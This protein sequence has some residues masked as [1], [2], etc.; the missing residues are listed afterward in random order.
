MSDEQKNINDYASVSISLASPDEIRQWS[1]GEVKKSETI[2]Y[3]TY[4]PE[5]EGL[6]CERIFGPE[7]DWECSC[8]K[9]K[10]IK[11]K[12]IVCDRCGVKITHSRV[13]RERMGHITLAAP[14]VHIW[15]FKTIPSKL[16]NL[17]GVKTAPL[18]RVIY[19]QDYIVIDPGNTE[20]KKCQVLTEQEYR[21]YLDQYGKAFTAGMGAE[22]IKEIL[23]T[24]NLKELSDKLREEL[25]STRSK[26]KVED[27]VKRLKLV[28]DLRDS[29]NRP[30]WLVLDVL[31]V[32]PPELRPLVFLESG[33]FATSDLNDL[34]RRVINRN[35]RLKKLIALKAPDVIVR[36]EKRML[37]QSVDALFDNSR[38][39][40][41]VMGTN[42]RSLKSLTDLIK[43]KQGRFRENLLGKRVDY[44]ARSVIVVG[45]ELKLHQC[46]L[47][48]KIALELYQPFIIRRLK[49]L[50]FADTIKSAKKFIE[51]KDPEVWDVLDE[52]IHHHP[53]L[54]NRAPTLH[55]MGIQAFEP[56]L[57]EGNA[58]RLHPLV[59]RGFNADFD[60]DT[61]AVHLPLSVEAQIEA[62][63]LM[64]STNNIFSPADGRPIMAPSQD[65]VMG[66]YFFSCIV[67]GCRGE[68]QFFSSPQEV[69]TAF[70]V[71]AL[72]L[73]AKIHVA[74]SPV[75]RAKSDGV[76]KEISGDRI[77]I[78]TDVYD[79]KAING[80]LDSTQYLAGVL[81]AKDLVVGDK[82]KRGQVISISDVI[83][84]DGQHEDCHVDSKG[85]K[86]HGVYSTNV[87]RMIFNDILG[88]RLPYYN[89]LLR[90]KVLAS[91]INDC[92]TRYTRQET[93]MMVDDIKDFG[94]KAST[95][96]GLSFSVADL[97]VTQEKQ[98]LIADADA[99]VERSQSFYEKGAITDQERYKEVIETWIHCREELYKN[100]M[101]TLQREKLN[102]IYIMADSGA[103]GGVAQV[104]QL[105]GMRG[106]MAKPSGEILEIP[107]T[108]NFRD[109]LGV[110]E[111]FSST[112]GSRKGLAD[113]ALKT[114]DS[115]YMTRKLADVVQ[116]ITVTQHDC[117]TLNGVTK[118]ELWKGDHVEIPMWQLLNG[119]VSRHDI[120]DR[121]SGELVVKENEIFDETKARKVEKLGYS[122]I[123]VRSPL[124]CES[125]TGICQMCYGYDLSTSRLV[126]LGTAVGIIAA[127]SIGEPGTQL[128]MQTF[129]IGGVASYQLEQND[130]KTRNGGTV[131][132]E[133]LRIVTNREGK[134][135]VI[136]RNGELIVEPENE[137]LDE[138][139]RF[140]VPPGAILKVKDGDKVKRGTVMAQFEANTAPIIAHASGR[141]RFGDI[142]P[143]K[144]V[145]EDVDGSTG[146]VR[147][148]VMDHRGELHP[149]III[150]DKSGQVL[151]TYPV[152]EKAT[153]EVRE[154]DE[155][156]PGDI[157]AKTP[158]LLGGTQDITG[159]L[160]RVAELFEARKPKDPAILSEVDGIVRFEKKLVRSKRV[161][162]VITESGEE[163]AYQVP[164]GKHVTVHDGDHVHAG[165]RLTEGPLVPHD[166]LRIKGEEAVMNYL[167]SEVQSVYR[168]QNVSISDKHIEVIVSQMI[169][170]VMISKTGDS[171]FLPKTIVD[172]CEFN[173]VNRDLKKKKLKPSS[174]ETQLM[175][176]TKA[177]L[178]SDSFLSAASFQDTTK[179]LSE[180]AL[181]SKVDTLAGLKEN[182]ILGHR[183]PA[184]TG[185][186]GYQDQI[187]RYNVTPEEL[188]AAR[189]RIQPQVEQQQAA[190]GAV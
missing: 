6:F 180:A 189:I 170:K 56:V 112:H 182:V 149:E 111:Y 161:I 172:R 97:V 99:K 164:K 186:S 75:I 48:K 131:R 84:D 110:L 44:S 7:K 101:E 132:F 129:H 14:I 33:N 137:K 159:G 58:I 177:A 142:I 10:G 119:R 124:T 49:D 21:V 18:E 43:G 63:T 107:I 42:N 29:S 90:S 109:G 144:T 74:L 88:P 114:A 37:Q 117:K 126:E 105:A 34:Y 57:I 45:P 32:I 12:D 125:D 143:G 141:V 134:T 174:G 176:I 173:R 140:T 38:S 76:V 93:I 104:G 138:K 116:N 92:Y 122:R 55:R 8:G 175:G 2:N 54:L 66:S 16:G 20:L 87:G 120:V 135:V 121:K 82:V 80:S 11:N 151:A 4:R 25:V 98:R 85:V 94:F 1:S 167:V 115:G 13:R 71:N 190:E 123:R 3:R 68:G 23:K 91:V 96:S 50:G 158:R 15:F 163:K 79:L 139:E 108:G 179:V 69:F 100:V 152:P 86:H 52:V 160:P 185:Y 166:I 83:G 168:A 35:N 113:T 62:Y 106:L 153:I 22:A 27:T 171:H 146:I 148:T 17:L 9:Y 187:V 36:N 67:P 130:I 133:K 81:P 26:Q 188:D 78:G 155:V 53:V 183:I 169:R 72:D 59:C 128:T 178:R 73:H 40:R 154:G 165:D 61:M 65:M 147:L 60:G 19:F 24:L 95:I 51:R 162:S 64:L 156:L 5:K 181:K 31:P 39:K 46:G 77:V 47:P 150:E 30:E 157:I 28:E 145:S 41:S 127:Q 136:N 70:S 184:G 103:R 89:R 102:P 118:Q